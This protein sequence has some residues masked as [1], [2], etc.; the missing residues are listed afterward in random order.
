M[1][2][3]EATHRGG[4]T[5]LAPTQAE[6]KM[7]FCNPFQGKPAPLDLVGLFQFSPLTV[8]KIDGVPI[9]AAFADVVGD[10][11]ARHLV[12]VMK[13]KTPATEDDLN[14]LRS[15]LPASGAGLVEEVRAALNG[16]NEAQVRLTSLT[17]WE[18]YLGG[19]GND[20]AKLSPAF[21]FLVEVERASANAVQ[22]ISRQSFRLAAKELAQQPLTSKILCPESLAGIEAATSNQGLVLYR[23]AGAIESHLAWIA[24]LDVQTGRDNVW[25]RSLVMELLPTDAKPGRNPTARFFDWL[26]REAGANSIQELHESRMLVDAGIDMDLTTLKRWS[27]GTFQ[28][29]QK[30]LVQIVQ[31]LFDEGGQEKAGFLGYC[32]R[33]LNF[34]GHFSQSLIGRV[35]SIAGAVP[36]PK[37]RPWPNYPFRHESFERWSQARYSYWLD[38]HHETLEGTVRTI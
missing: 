5:P 2:L 17:T 35:S 26:R 19:K 38:Y 27:A 23:A 28:P 21:A 13:G 36:E 22:L 6:C 29:N 10:T 31:A 14:Q 1:S 8:E 3:H 16:D 4:E 15:A 33:H 34:I 9:R 12:D 20:I 30:L 37:L 7:N 18:L 24:A 32:M 25:G 11:R